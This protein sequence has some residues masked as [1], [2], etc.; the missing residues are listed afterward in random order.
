MKDILQTL[1]S[2]ELLD[3]VTGPLPERPVKVYAGFDPSADCLH[4]GNFVGIAVLRWFQKL[5][6]TPVV[7]LGG[8]TG[9][10]GDP[11][12][13][14][15]ERNL[16]DSATLEHNVR[17][18]EKLMRHLLRSEEGLP[19]PV[20]LNNYDWFQNFGFIDFLRD[21]GKHFRV[22]AMLGKESVRQRLNSEEGISF[23][24][25]CYQTLQGYDFYHLFEH[26]DVMIQCGGSDQWGN[27]TAGCDL[28]SRKSSKAEK[29]I[30][31]SWPLLLR[32]DGRKFGK[33]E[34]G[35]VWLSEEK[36]SAYKF[37]QYAFQ[38][39]DADVFKFMR[40]LTMMPL[41]EIQ[42]YEKESL[43]GRLEPNAAQRRYA[44][45]LTKIVH[46]EKSLEEAIESTKIAQPGHQVELTLTNLSQ[47]A[48][49]VPV[50]EKLKNDVLGKRIIDLIVEGALVGSK[51]D[52]RRLIENKG[53]YLNQ[54]VVEVAQ[55]VIQ[56]SDLIEN[57]VLLLSVGKKKR[58]IVKVLLG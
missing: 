12:G 51:A 6:Y 30:G 3:N 22:G 44:Q 39:P 53:V 56:E 2:R 15:K 26:H 16:L 9:M 11:S 49:V 4:L 13:K 19:E 48:Q 58:L 50:L 14:S 47:M 38:T 7:I 27:I 18:I 5:G 55:A 46:G 34:E 43:A 29:G 54:Q 35:A 45:E 1:K 33:S 23:T 37:Y 36:L 52:A 25:F 42:H 28:I 17:S 57:Q 8:A 32:S 10:I 24:E 20:F 40:R 31:L 41:E 21:V